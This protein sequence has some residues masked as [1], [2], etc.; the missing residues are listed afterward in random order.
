[1]TSRPMKETMS[2][3]PA[4]REVNRRREL[5]GVVRMARR[6]PLQL[7][8]QHNN[9]KVDVLL[10][11]INRITAVAVAIQLFIPGNELKVISIQ[12]PVTKLTDFVETIEI[13]S[14]IVSRCGFEIV[15]RESSLNGRLHVHSLQRCST[16]CFQT[17]PP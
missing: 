4:W 16:G 8:H 12:F 5:F 7:H 6:S 3:S 2:H 15:P 17:R 10:L 13:R 14:G 11:I 9:N 1:M